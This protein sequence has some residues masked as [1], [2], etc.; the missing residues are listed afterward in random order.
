MEYCKIDSFIFYDG[1][2]MKA[3]DLKID[4]FSQSLHYGNGVFEG[5]RAYKTESGSAVMFKA[6]EHY[7]RLLRSAEMLGI[8]LNYS[9]PDLINA[10]Y[11]LL[12]ANNL[13]EAY[14]RPLAIA[15][16]NM[17]FESNTNSHLIIAAWEMPL[18]FGNRLL[19]V[20]TSSFQRPNPKAFKIHAKC[21]G[22]YINSLMA[23]QE[24]KARGFDEALLTDINGFVAEGAGANIF[25]EKSGKLFTPPSDNILPGITRATVIELCHQLDIPVEEKLF[26]IDELKYADAAF[27]CG[28]AAEIVGLKSIDGIKFPCIWRETLSS[29]IQIAYRELVRQN[30][31]A[32]ATL[33]I[34]KN[35]YPDFVPAY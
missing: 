22:H 26:T 24:A 4:F 18:F 1:A 9:A 3:A 7:E 12:S 10:T 32:I 11:E 20:M 35:M 31:T 28:T 25:Y 29:K 21:S 16:A 8:R 13:P 34:P 27:F 2:Y 6:K 15:P 30:V 33:P 5:I 14:I 17:S 23:S 19:R